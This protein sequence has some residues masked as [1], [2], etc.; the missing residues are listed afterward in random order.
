MKRPEIE[1]EKA[2]AQNLTDAR[3]H[4]KG[5]LCIRDVSIRF[6]RLTVL[7]GEQA[8]GKSVSCKMFYFFTQAIRK[9]ALAALYAD[10]SYD[11]FIK[12]LRHEF[13]VI[14]PE[15]AW[16]TDTFV[17]EW[18]QG[19]HK[20]KIWHKG[21]QKKLHIDLFDIEKG[22]DKILSRVKTGPKRVS[23]FDVDYHDYDARMKFERE[24][25]KLV[26]RL[27]S[28]MA[29]DYIPAGRSFFSAIQDV[30]FTL[31]ANNIGIDYFLKEFGQKLESYRYSYRRRLDGSSF[32]ALQ[33]SILHGRY[34]Y[35]GKEQWILRDSKHKVRLA[36]ASSGQQEALPLLMVLAGGVYTRSRSKTIVVEEPEAHLYPTAQQKIVKYLGSR[37]AGNPNL[38]SVITTHSPFILCCLNN[39]LSGNAEL[40][41]Y[42]S[43]YH[44]YEGKADSIFNEEVHLIDAVRFDAISSDIA[45]NG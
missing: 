27:I 11:A 34:L 12:E 44:L 4:I 1:V 32:D 17:I 41:K 29:V 25:E 6:R 9:V 26:S 22:Y 40:Q 7:I 18:S 24:I 28:S 21:N 8:S 23:G 45:N 30:L 42:V 33:E 37:L 35:D 31:L 19:E 3:L 13:T 14:F 15:T 16:K 38:G 36:E 2:V 5:F 20:F 39:V 43:A 10:K